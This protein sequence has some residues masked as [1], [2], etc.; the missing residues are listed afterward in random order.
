VCFETLFF[1]TEMDFSKDKWELLMYYGQSFSKVK[2]I[3]SRKDFS[4]VKK[5]I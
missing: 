4:K 3:Y 2:K 1:F 5:Y